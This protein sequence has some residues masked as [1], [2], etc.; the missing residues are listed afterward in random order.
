M[1]PL[2]GDG[3]AWPDEPKEF[4]PDS[5]GPETPTVDEPTFETVPIED[6]PEDVAHNFVGALVMANVALLSLSLGVMLA[7]FRGDFE[8]GGAAMF[9]GFVATVFLGRYYWRFKTRDANEGVDT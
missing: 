2:G 7:Y 9:I 1:N 8:T 5:L 4:D 6:V 3:D